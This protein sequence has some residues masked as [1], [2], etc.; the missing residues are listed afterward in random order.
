MEETFHS[1]LLRGSLDLMILSV[2]A[3]GPKYGYALQQSLRT[4][5]VGRIDP[6]AGTLY[7]LLHRLEDDGL[8]RA[9]WDASTGRT[10]CHRTMVEESWPL[11]TAHLVRE[12]ASACKTSTREGES[13]LAPECGRFTR[14]A[15]NL[16]TSPTAMLAFF[17]RF[18]FPW[19][20]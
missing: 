3:D 18:H 8:I 14:R 17:W 7:P 12:E 16:C 4:A 2:L 13:C 10:S 15:V 1:D 9:K 19:K 11:H 20:I 6:K 5:S